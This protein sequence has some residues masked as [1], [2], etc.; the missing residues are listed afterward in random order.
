MA[1]EPSAHERV[2]AKATPAEAIACTKADSRVA[3]ERGD[4]IGRTWRGCFDWAWGGGVAASFWAGPGH[5]LQAALLPLTEGTEVVKC[6]KQG[7]SRTVVRVP[8]QGPKE[9]GEVPQRK[10]T[11]DQ[12]AQ[13]A[14]YW[15]LLVMGNHRDG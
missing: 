7:C 2:T 15:T 5:P 11:E 9:E 14:S 10:Y 4:L 13:E 1:A 3:E 6:R 8:K 12:R